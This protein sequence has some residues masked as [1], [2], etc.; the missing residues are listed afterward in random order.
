MQ[1]RYRA[2]LAKLQS[3]QAAA[4]NELGVRPEYGA[5]VLMPPSDY[6]SGAF[7]NCLTGSEYCLGF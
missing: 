4:R 3:K 7:T 5:P 6:L 1:R 2:R